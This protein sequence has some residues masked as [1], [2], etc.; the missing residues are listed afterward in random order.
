MGTLL[1]APGLV[2]ALLLPPGLLAG[3]EWASDSSSPESIQANSLRG[4][5]VTFA[6]RERPLALRLRP[7]PALFRAAPFEPPLAAPGESPTRATL[8]APAARLLRVAAAK[9]RPGRGPIISP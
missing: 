9:P 2:L 5:L 4:S 6:L 1:F 8:A 3:A 7:L